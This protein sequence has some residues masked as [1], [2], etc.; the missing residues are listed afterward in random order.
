MRHS[1]I[2]AFTS[3]ALV[4]AP[5]L[6]SDAQ[7]K[8]TIEQFLSPAYPSELVSAKK[9]DRVAW[10][11]YDRGR[12][13]IYT[14]A[15]PDFKPV[16]LT[17]FLDDD[18]IILSELEISDDGSIVTFVRGSEPN[19]IGWIAN[20]SSDPQGPDRAIWAAYTNGSAAWRLGSGAGPA[21]SPD[22]H[23]VAFS[24]DG[25][26]FRY[27]IVPRAAA[28]TEKDQ[29]PYIK[30]WG[31]NANPR[32]SPD[33]SQARVRQRA[34]QSLAD[35]RLRRSHAA[36]RTT[37]RPASTSTAV[38][39]GRPTA[40]GSRSSATRHSVRTT[41]A[42]RRREPRKSRRP[43][44]GWSRRPRAGRG[45]RG[46]AAG[47]AEGRA[48]GLYRAV[49]TGGYT[50]SLM[51]ADIAAVRRPPADARRTSSGTTSRTTR[52]S[53]RSPAS[54]GRGRTSSSRRSRRSGFAGTRWRSTAATTPVELTPGEG[55]VETTGLS[56]DGT[57]LFY[58]T[59]VG[60]IDRRHLWKVPT[61]GGPAVADHDRRR[62]RDVSRAALV[63]KAGRGA[64]VRRHAS[65]VGRHRVSR[66]WRV[67]RNECARR[68]S[69]APAGVPGGRA[70][71]A[72]SG[73]PQGRRWIRVPQ[74][75]LPAEG[76][77]G[78]RKAPG[79]HLRPRRSDPA[80]AARLPLH[81]FLRDG[82][83]GERVAREPGLH[84]DVGEL[85]LGRS[86]TGSRSARRRTRAA[87]ATP[88]IAT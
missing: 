8:P 85:P 39:R 20:P 18:G 56:R 1:C 17:K 52:R 28:P 25:Q 7:S 29:Q 65:D 33:G 47:A 81:G 79:D 76:P 50:I 3:A 68:L 32:W 35:R 38:R 41:G 48:D 74:S 14:A 2:R 61:A 66:R 51:V 87:A 60:D 5:F 84:R 16:R 26:I 6:G 53:R 15:A 73:R 63:R 44:G 82:V 88:S 49:F 36:P 30:E 27:Q 77:Q 21:L 22:G 69:D 70:G 23:N 4:A 57:T 31:R 54:R 37:C 24:R 46:G 55:A 80:D 59:N 43:G 10:I 67:E 75:A 62:D 71:R 64:D 13:N 58:A 19:R 40:N 11:A 12:R 42:G 45:G 83:R 34:R 72:D 9:A 78:G 86:A